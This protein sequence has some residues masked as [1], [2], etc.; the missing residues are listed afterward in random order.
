MSVKKK[1]TAEA[2]ASE[3]ISLAVHTTTDGADSPHPSVV[4]HYETWS[5][6]LFYLLVESQSEYG[7]P[8]QQSFLQA[9]GLVNDHDLD[10]ICRS[11]QG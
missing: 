2:V 7:K 4:C 8:A 1:A 5:R 10:C 3:S 6:R 9:T 11:Q